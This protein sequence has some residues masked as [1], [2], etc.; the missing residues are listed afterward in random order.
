MNRHRC[1]AWIAAATGLE[2]RR[3]TSPRLQSRGGGRPLSRWLPVI[4][5]IGAMLGVRPAGAVPNYTI[6]DLGTLGGSYAVPSALNAS[7]QVVGTSMTAGDAAVH[8]FFWADGKMQ[9]LGTLGGPTSAANAINA[10]GQVAGISDRALVGSHAFLWSNGTMQDLGSLGGSSSTAWGIN[11]AGQVVGYSLTTG[12]AAV[13]AFLWANGQMQD[14][15]T[16]GG[17]NSAAYAVNDAGQVFGSSDL[18]GDQYQHAFVWANSKMQDLGTLAGNF[19]YAN[20][21]NAGGQIVGSATDADN[22]DEHAVLWSNGQIQDL[23]TLGGTNSIAL[24]LN[25]SGQVVG[26]SGTIAE[27]LAGPGAAV[28]HAFVW[29]GGTMTDLNSL[30]PAGSGWLVFAAF[31]I[32]DAGQIVGSGVSNGQ[33]R[34]CLLTPAP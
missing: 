16:L 9:D 27:L 20:N 19:S 14:L 5:L 26:N 17:S 8:A 1:T 3:I 10:A 28:Q 23:G 21:G 18:A 12:D 2:L 7:G 31:A 25:T 22:L 11:A 4:P 29:D 15:G 6:S 32:N 33:E 24:A 13:H 30:L 34:A